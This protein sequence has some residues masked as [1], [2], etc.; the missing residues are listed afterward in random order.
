MGPLKN[1]LT[2]VS[3]LLATSAQTQTQPNSKQETLVVNII[4]SEPSGYLDENGKITGFHADFF[5]KLGEISKLD[6]ELQLL[7]FARGLR[8]MKNGSI[9]AGLLFKVKKREAFLDPITYLFDTHVSAIGRKGITPKSISQLE[10]LSISRMRGVAVNE[11]YDRVEKK[12]PTI[13][14]NNYPQLIKMLN[15]KHIDVAVGNFYSIWRLSQQMGIQKK[16]EF[17]GLLLAKQEVWLHFSKKS[18]RKHLIPQIK[19]A[20]SRIKETDFIDKLFL[21]YYSIT[22]KMAQNLL[23]ESKN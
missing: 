15:S 1:T 8:A 20:L 22:P 2:V 5:R 6:I 12:N 3:L 14:S 9:D 17:P 11:A 4:G 19:E 21:K 7:P 13:Q 18:K 23:I 10:H 16:I